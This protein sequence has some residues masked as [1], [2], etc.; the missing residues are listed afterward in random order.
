MLG[1]LMDLGAAIIKGNQLGTK[2]DARSA[3]DLSGQLL[4]GIGSLYDW[5]AKAYDET[6]YKGVKGYDAYKYP[7][8]IEGLD[9]IKALHLKSLRMT[10]FKFLGPAAMFSVVLDGVDAWKSGQRGQRGLAISQA[11]SAFGAIFTIGGA[12]AA[13]FEAGI[14]AGA[15]AWG[16]TAAILGLVG[17][18]LSIGGTIFVLLLS[19]EKWITWLRDIPLNKKRKGEKPIHDNLRDTLQDLANAQRELQPA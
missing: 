16:I 4:Q 19:E 14:G 13:I 7:A 2:L 6:I 17:A 5:R 12:G 11:A 10:A 9:S 15:A 8:L 1:A 18:V 3:F